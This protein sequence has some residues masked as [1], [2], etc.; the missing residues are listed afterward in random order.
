MTFRLVFL[1]A[2]V[3]SELQPPKDSQVFDLLTL[4]QVAI[5]FEYIGGWSI[6]SKVVAR[7]RVECLA[8]CLQAGYYI[9]TYL[10]AAAVNTPNCH[11]HRW[12]A[13]VKLGPQPGAAMYKMRYG[14]CPRCPLTFQAV[15]PYMENH[16][17][18]INE[19]C[20]VSLD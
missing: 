7:S 1:I 9:A 5:N 8:L 16:F 2:L 4:N 14:K 18:K 15:I 11:F 20:F 17:N 10:S 12:M 13:T 6:E 19:I 3:A